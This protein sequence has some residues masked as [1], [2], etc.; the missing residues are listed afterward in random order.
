MDGL[1][2]Q[3]IDSDQQHVCRSFTYLRD[4]VKTRWRGN[5]RYVDRN[6]DLV[7]DEKHRLATADEQK[8]LLEEAEGHGHHGSE[9]A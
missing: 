1:Q 7:D 9:S 8:F 6:K 4:W 3:Y 2:H 5:A